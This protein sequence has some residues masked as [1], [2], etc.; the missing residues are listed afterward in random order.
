LSSTEF[1]PPRPAGVQR[2]VRAAKPTRAA[3]QAVDADY[4]DRSFGYRASSAVFDL[5]A[6]QLR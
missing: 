1:K 5:T 6:H 3:N 2:L 4:A